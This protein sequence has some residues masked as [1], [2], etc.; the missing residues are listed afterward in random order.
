MPNTFIYLD[1]LLLATKTIKEH[2]KSLED[3]FKV[4]SDNHMALSIDKCKFAQSE[5][6][7]LG[8]KVTKSG[9]RPLP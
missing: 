6:D 3:I 5:V 7:Y 9:I 4:L 2:D 1:D 8:Y